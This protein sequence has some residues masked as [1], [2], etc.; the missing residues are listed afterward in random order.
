[1]A[2]LAAALVHPLMAGYGLAAVLVVLLQPRRWGAWGLGAAA[3]LVAA[4]VEARAPRSLPTT[5][6]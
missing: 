3:L 6:G 1:M 2:L 4:V 5:S